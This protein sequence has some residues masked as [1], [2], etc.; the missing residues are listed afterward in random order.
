MEEEEVLESELKKRLLLTNVPLLL[1][2]LSITD[3]ATILEAL[4]APQTLNK[5]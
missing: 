4:K 3:W 1:I 5:A 2:M